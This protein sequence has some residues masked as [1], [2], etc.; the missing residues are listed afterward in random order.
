[1][2]ANKKEQEK[3]SNAIPTKDK[4]SVNSQQPKTKTQLTYA[5]PEKQK[6]VEDMK[7]RYEENRQAIIKKIFEIRNTP[8][9][10]GKLPTL[11]DIEEELNYAISRTEIGD[12]LNG[13]ANAKHLAK[14]I[15]I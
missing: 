2:K 4:K 12:I 8:K 15:K 11:R 14:R 3:K 9:E 7:K 6:V 13:K 1:M 10:N 5:N